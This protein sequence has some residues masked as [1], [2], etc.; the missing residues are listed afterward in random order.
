MSLRQFVLS[1]SL[2]MAAFAT[3]AQDTNLFV[4]VG[5]K[6]SIDEFHPDI[7]PNAILMDEAF[8]ARYRILRPVYGS[9]PDAEIEFEAYDHYGR[10]S[11]ENYPFV[12]LFVSAENDRYYHQKYQFFP[13]FLTKTGVWAGCGSPY[14]FE[15]PVHHGSLKPQKLDFGA[16]AFFDISGYDKRD[17]RKWFPQEDFEIRGKRAYCLRGSPV[18]DLFQVKKQG[19]LTARG[20]FKELPE[21]EG[22]TIPAR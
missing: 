17:I 5:E 15:P 9:Y 16:D 11:F 6:I 7:G 20:L 13:V 18:E 10:P 19:V 4:F 14:R 22:P 1:L 3:R 8:K 2:G 12:L 21:A